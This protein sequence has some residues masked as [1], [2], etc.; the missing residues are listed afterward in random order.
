MVPEDTIPTDIYTSSYL[1]HHTV[2]YRAHSPVD[3]LMDSR[4][5]RPSVAHLQ[6]VE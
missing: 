2:Q 5:V 6:P 3:S 1:S 4:A